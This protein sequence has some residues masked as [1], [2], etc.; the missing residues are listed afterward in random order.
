MSAHQDLAVGRIPFLVCAPFFHSSLAGMPGFRF[1][2]GVPSFLNAELRAGRVDAAPSSCIEYGQRF[3]DYR[4]LPG[5]STS[6][7]LEMRSVLFLSGKPWEELQD[8]PV[9]LSP[10]SATSNVLF[11]ILCA[12]RFR[13]RPRLLGGAEAETAAAVGRVFIGDRALE[14]ALSGRWPHRY[15]LGEL[16]GKWQGLPFSFGLWMVRD[17]ACQARP[18]SV[19]RLQSLLR[20]AL[21]SFRT[22]PQA[23]LDAWIKAYP[24]ALPRPLMLRFYETAD[25]GFSPEHALS[26]QTFYRLAWEDGHL[27][28]V[29]ELRFVAPAD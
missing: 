28:E 6:S 3:R 23:A 1:V 21:E 25:Y 11:Q 5:I 10:A 18:S 17:E 16:W 15:D 4:L 9:A 12:R 13:V 7:R 14:E 24:T 8:Q 26:L 19:A 2:D 22:N 29:P 27:Q 20:A